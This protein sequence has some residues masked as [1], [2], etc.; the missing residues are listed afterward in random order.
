[1]QR[2]NVCLFILAMCIAGQAFAGALNVEVDFSVPDGPIKPMH[3]VGQPPVLSH[4]PE[5]DRLFHYLT[6]AGI[7]YSRLHDVGG[8]YGKNVFVDIPNL[9]RDFDADET[10]PASYDFAFTDLLISSLVKHNVEPVFR[11]G[12][13]IENYA[14]VRRYNINPPEDF[15]KWARIC[16]HVI[17]HY[18][19][20]WADGF[21]HKITYW[22][23]WNEPDN[24][25]EPEENAMWNGD[26]MS[27]CRLYEITSKHLKKAFPHLKIGGYASCGFYAAANSPAVA[28]ANSSLRTQYFIDCYT[29]FLAFVKQTD[30]PLDFFS[31]HSYSK[32]R[33]ILRQVDWGIRTLRRAGFEN[34]ETSLNEWLPQPQHERL[35]TAEQAADICAAIIGMQHS[36]LDSAML[37]DARCGRGNYSPLFNPFTYK[38][39]KAY[40][41]LK[42]FNALYQLKTAVKVSSSASDDV[43]V[44]AA[45]ENAE[46]AVL[47]AN[48][49]E[50]KISLSLDFGDYKAVE[51]RVIDRTRTDTEISLP[52]VMTPHSVLLIRCRADAASGKN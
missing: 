37:Y 38:P 24:Q 5:G 14:Q 32:P 6:E 40:Y 18:T 19:E 42:A 28:A 17:R 41:V 36:D 48:I 47:L 39:H 30:S 44:A 52:S 10:N 9:F 45:V 1:M 46:G 23:I 12:V 13:T 2:I 27:Y 8:A 20:G 21:H 33:E 25:P 7:P 34:T 29:N 11:L 26:F 35:G 16:E 50:R 3:G 43:W 49:S 15:E 22:E 51:C 4:G 31:F